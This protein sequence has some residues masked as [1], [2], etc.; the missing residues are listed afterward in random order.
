MDHYCDVRGKKIKNKSKFKH[1]Q[2]LNHNGFDKRLGK[3]IQSKI[4]NSLIQM[5]YL[6]F[7]SNITIEN[8]IFISLYMILN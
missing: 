2:S 5:E 7:I 8:S 4:P 3:N 6:I 1:F